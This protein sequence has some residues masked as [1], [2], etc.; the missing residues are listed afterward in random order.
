MPDW[1][2]G[3]PNRKNEK[4]R[5]PWRDLLAINVHWLGISTITGS[6]TPLLLP[7]LIALFAPPDRKNTY[8]A[9]VRVISL[10]LAMMVQ[11][12]AGLLSDRSTLRW[13]RRRPFIALGT[14]LTVLSLVVIGLSP[15]WRTH[16]GRCLLLPWPMPFC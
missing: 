3:V 14:G 6:L 15:G 16:P 4:Q 1:R 13:G 8:L 7:Y 12:M 5:L 10:A 11:P 9:T 2:D